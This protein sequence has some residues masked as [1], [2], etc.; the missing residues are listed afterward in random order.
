ML[1]SASL[2]IASC[3]P[4]YI[5][6]RIANKLNLHHE[7]IRRLAVKEVVNNKAVYAQQLTSIQRRMESIDDRCKRMHNCGQYVDSIEVSAT[8]I[9][10]CDIIVYEEQQNALKPIIWGEDRNQNTVQVY[11]RLSNSLSD[12]KCHYDLLEPTSEK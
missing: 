4:E 7:T 11:L 2:F 5:S 3:N 9:L 8:S 12:S 1:P 6:D 10:N